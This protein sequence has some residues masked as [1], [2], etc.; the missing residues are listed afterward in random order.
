MTAVPKAARPSDYLGRSSHLAGPFPFREPCHFEPFLA[1]FSFP[2]VARMQ[3][4]DPR[5]IF[6]TIENGSVPSG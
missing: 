6:L 4:M 3:R 2:Q 5:L 1:E